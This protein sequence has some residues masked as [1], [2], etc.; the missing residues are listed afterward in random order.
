MI[1][2]A[3]CLIFVL[4]WLVSCGAAA[5]GAQPTQGVHQ[6]GKGS[7]N[8]SS[9]L[10]E[11]VG[12][13]VYDIDYFHEYLQ[14]GSEMQRMWCGYGWSDDEIKVREN[15]ARAMAAKTGPSVTYFISSLGGDSLK[16]RIVNDEKKEMLKIVTNWRMVGSDILTG[17]QSLNPDLPVSLR[18]DGEYLY[19]MIRMTPDKM[20]CKVVSTKPAEIWFASMRLKRAQ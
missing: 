18:L 15:A 9:L 19:P 14:K 11:I 20:S 12:T 8:V 13:W 3:T 17:T 16:V 5:T 6:G 7:E 4:S 1:R 10:H 2:P